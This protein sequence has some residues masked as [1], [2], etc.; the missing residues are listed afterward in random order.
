MK[1]PLDISQMLLPHSLE[2]V[3][4]LETTKVQIKA[5]NDDTEN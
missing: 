2:P 1:F 3:F 5:Y 4:Y